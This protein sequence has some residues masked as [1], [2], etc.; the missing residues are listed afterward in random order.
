MIHDVGIHI[1]MVGLFSTGTGCLTVDNAHSN[2]NEGFPFGYC[3]DGTSCIPSAYL[4]KQL[5]CQNKPL[6]PVGEIF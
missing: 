1:H 5:L 3:R 2:K 4:R 6:N